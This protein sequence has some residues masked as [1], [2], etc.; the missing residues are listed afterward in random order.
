MKIKHL[1]T[2]LPTVSTIAATERYH[3]QELKSIQAKVTALGWEEQTK[4]IGNIYKEV[5]RDCRV[6]V[7]EKRDGG[8]YFLRYE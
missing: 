8:D 7:F 5:G 3:K 6:R 4:H 1:G 2:I